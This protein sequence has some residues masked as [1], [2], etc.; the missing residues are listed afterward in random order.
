MTTAMLPG[1]P[2]CWTSTQGIGLAHLAGGDDRLDPDH[3]HRDDLPGLRDTGHLADHTHID[4]LGLDLAETGQETRDRWLRHQDT[5]RSQHGVDHVA[6][7]Q[8]E[9]LE[10]PV[11]A[12]HRQGRL[13]VSFLLLGRS[14]CVG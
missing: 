10:H 3:H 1:R 5:G 13:G 9:L 6:R 14:N 7:A 11:A 4:H 2:I 8:R 12:G